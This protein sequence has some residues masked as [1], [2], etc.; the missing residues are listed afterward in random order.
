MEVDRQTHFSRHFM[1][2]NQHQSRPKNF[3]KTLVAALISQATNLGVVAM[4]ASVKG[5]TVD[6]L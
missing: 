2:I 6:M 4:S 5:V 1:P 3:Y